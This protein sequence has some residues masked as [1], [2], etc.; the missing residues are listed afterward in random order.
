MSG[1]ILT[2]DNPQGIIRKV[3]ELTCPTCKIVDYIPRP[4]SGNPEDDPNYF[5][6]AVT[7]KLPDGTVIKLW[8]CLN[9]TGRFYTVERKNA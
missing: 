7:E 6:C 8:L 9:C 3:N 2:K 5:E 1:S 4:L